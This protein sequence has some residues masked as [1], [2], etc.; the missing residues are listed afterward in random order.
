MEAPN[1]MSVVCVDLNLSELSFYMPII[2]PY[3]RQ[4]ACAL[5]NTRAGILVFGVVP[6]ENNR[7]QGLWFNDEGRLNFMNH[8]IGLILKEFGQD[9][10]SKCKVEFHALRGSAQRFIVVVHICRGDESRVYA[11][12]ISGIKWMLNGAGN[13][14]RL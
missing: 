11:D 6:Q 7:V 8:S 14:V 4:Y 1:N 3:L 12:P 9:I 10:P 5:L 2:D 13:C